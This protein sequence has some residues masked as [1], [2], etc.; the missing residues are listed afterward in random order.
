MTESHI[1]M[2]CAH[3]ERDFPFQDSDGRCPHCHAPW[4]QTYALYYNEEGQYWEYLT[5][6][7]S[8]EKISR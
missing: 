6:P 7:E 8:V 1:R 2:K 4:Y 3:C 5:K